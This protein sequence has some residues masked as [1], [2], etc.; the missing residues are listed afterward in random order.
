MKQLVIK[1][2][3]DERPPLTQTLIFGM[4]WLAITIATVIIIGK[5]VAGLHFTD[6]DRQLIYMQKLFFVIAVSLFLQI[7]WGHRLP[8]ITGPATVLLVAILA[9]IGSDINAIYTSIAVGGGSLVLLCVTGLFSWIS[10]YFTSRVVATILILIALTITPTILNLILVSASTETA[11]TNLGFALL[12]FIL[13]IIADRLL[14]G[15]WKTTMIVWAIIVGSICYLLLLPPEALRDRG[16]LGLVSN[17][18]TDFTTTLIWEPGLLIS[19]G[20]CFIALSINDLG[21]I[22][23]V[24]QLIKAPG[25]KRRVTAGITLS[26]LAN[27]LA[28][29]FGVIGPVNFS[30]SA[31]IIAANGNASRFTLLPT[32]LGLLAMAFLPGVVAF[33]WNVPSVVVGTIL[34]YIMCSQ[35]AAGLMVAFG[36]SGFTFRDGLV[37]GIP[38]MV[39]ILV[40]YLPAAVTA[41]FPPLFMPIAGNGFVMG[42]LAV[43]VL[44]HIVYRRD[45]LQSPQPSP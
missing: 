18:F 17:F 40:S 29:F 7:L 16:Q 8:L 5:V 27:V 14:P 28:G 20:I 10:R 45:N 39:S 9:G 11:L 34:L 43:L 37:I 3:L 6:F 26:G 31:G 35:L 2:G 32:S 24:G 13:M 44:E 25:M 42:V 12:F 15:I 33:A 23:A 22:Q 41:T 36:T 21:S 19:F 38:M 4:Q 1:Y 30:M